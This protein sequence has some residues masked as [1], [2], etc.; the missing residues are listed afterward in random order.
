MMMKRRLARTIVVF[1]LFCLATPLYAAT[2][3][4]HTDGNVIKDPCGNIIILRGIDLIDLGFLQDWEGGA[5]AMV[6]R[7][8]NQ[9]DPCGSSPGWYPRVLRINITPP[10][11]VSGWPHPFNPNNTDL[12]NLLR[13]VVDYCKTKDLYAIVDWH[14]VDNTYSHVASTNQFWTYMAPK[15]ANDS[16]VIF[17]LFNEPI[18]TTFGSDNA[19]WLSVRTNMN[20]W[21]SI[22]RTYAPNNLILVAGASWSQTIGPAATYPLTGDNIAIVSHI[23]PG[24]WLSSPVGNNWYTTNIKNCLN[25]YPVFMSEWGFYN[26]SSDTLGYG[27]ITNYGQP[28]QNFREAR[29]ISNS[30]W[31]SSYDWTPTMFTDGLVYKLRI[32]PYEMGGFVK[33]TLYLMRNNNQP[34]NGD[35][36]PPAA[37]T[38]L[39]ATPSTGTVTLTWNSNTEGD[40]YGYDIYRSSTSGGQINRLNLVRSKTPAYTDTNVGGTRTYYYVVTAVDTSFNSS[41]DSIEVSATVPADSTPP[42]APSG[43]SATAGDANVLLVWNNNTE[44]D[45]N[46]YNVYRSTT[47]GGPYIRQNGGLLSSPTFIDANVTN[48]IIYYYV[49]TA[50][51]TSLNESANSSQVSAKPQTNS[52]VGIISSWTTGTTNTAASGYN[53]ALVFVAHAKSGSSGGTPSL[54]GVTYGGQ[55]MTK[56]IDK[57]TGSGSSQAYVAAFILNDA[58]INAAANTTFTPTWTSTPTYITYTSVFLQHVNQTTPVG[59]TDSNGVTSST[60]VSTSALTTNNGDMVIEN[61]ASSI[62]GTYTVT[63][64]WTKDVDLSV[65]SYDGMDGHKPATG[66]SETP[67]ITQTSGNHSLIGFVVKM[68]PNLPPAAPVGLSATSSVGIV[69]LDWNNNTELDL[70]GYNIY[71]S[72]TSGSGYVKLNS[73]L[74]TSSNYTDTNVVN[75]TTYYYVVTA[76]DTAGLESVNSSEVSATP[77]NPASGTGSILRE[78]WNDIPGTI[79]DLLSNVNYPDNPSGRELVT[80]LE[81]PVNWGE[82][83]GSRFLGYLNPVTSGTYTF[84]IAADD[85][86]FMF[87]S[88]DDDP[89]NSLLIAWTQNPTGWRVWD[90]Y[91]SQQSSP[92]SL[93]AGQKYYFE[94][95]HK[96]DTDNDNVSVA[97]EGPGISQQV[98]DG[99]Y[100]SPCDLEFVDFAGFAGQWGQ[101]DCN[102]D[103]NWCSG[104]DFDRNGTVDIDDLLSFADGWLVGNNPIY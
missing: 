96:Q 59:T 38:G 87:L 9:N 56:I 50:V 51:D 18:N 21:I 61:A 15:F 66:A 70:A 95:L 32:G 16:H 4:L 34:S 22:V 40:L 84:W 30:A 28:L 93:V 80:K 90:T 48:G 64:G 17:E 63:S 55:A 19:N 37:P 45:F 73:T 79:D 49:V 77:I 83:Y 67:S 6:D 23:Y 52:I 71:R 104:A 94:V 68:A 44:V 78:W 101:I 72:T 33:D 76:V 25:R 103:N 74:L 13:S 7:L 88:T 5:T 54:T 98:I 20:S 92:I 57:L 24:H 85:M 10:D 46:G 42:A 12:Y 27:S 89:A 60:T 91:S 82:S 102:A 26:N 47:S 36:I 8:T 39:M 29:N 31:V 2:P 69:L 100:L 75:G 11:S 97:W 99:V 81:G 62:I 3:W 35:T 58:N 43:L 41:A 53:R 1:A 86:G 14:Y 65:S